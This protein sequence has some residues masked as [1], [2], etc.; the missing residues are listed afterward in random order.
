[1]LQYVAVCCNVLQ[2]VAMCC[3]VLQCVAVCCSVLQ[4][5]V[6]RCSDLGG[7]A[8][9]PGHSLIGSKQLSNPAWA[10][11]PPQQFREIS[12]IVTADGC[13]SALQCVAVRCRALQCVAV[14]T[15]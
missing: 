9:K 2:C 13:C 3:S 1:M 7:K 4:C 10:S 12:S 6:L 14:F 8:A 5:V 15:I 11:C